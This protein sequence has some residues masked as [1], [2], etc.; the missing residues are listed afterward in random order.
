MM[1]QWHGPGGMALDIGLQLS[2]GVLVGAFTGASWILK[3]GYQWLS[4]EDGSKYLEYED[5]P[6]DGLDAHGQVVG[7]APMVDSGT[8]ECHWARRQERIAHR[9]VSGL[10]PAG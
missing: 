1:C 7:T 9:I 3:R 8:W 4:D 10:D 2:P 5:F 6:F